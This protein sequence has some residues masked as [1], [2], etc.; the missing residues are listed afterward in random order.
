MAEFLVGLWP[1]SAFEVVEISTSDHS[2][3][4]YTDDIAQ[5]R[6]K[7]AYGVSD[8]AAAAEGIPVSEQGE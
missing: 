5:D 6:L 3:L 2:Y 7:A 1:G 8:P 4:L